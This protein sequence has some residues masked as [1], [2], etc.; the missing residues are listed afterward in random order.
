MKTIGIEDTLTALNRAGLSLSTKTVSTVAKDGA[1]STD[2]GVSD[3]ITLSAH[4]K[5]M[6]QQAKDG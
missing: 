5:S 1:A 3:T 2:K 6:L 4:A